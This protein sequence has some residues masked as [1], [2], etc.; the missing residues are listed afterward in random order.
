[1]QAQVDDYD[2]EAL[3]ELLKRFDVRDPE[4][5]GALSAPYPFNLMFETSIGPTGVH[6]GFLRPE[7]AQG[8][9]V[10]FA[11]LLEFNGGR[12][13]FAGAT[14]G[15]AFRNE[16]SPRAGLLRVRE[17]TLAEI[18]HFID[19]AE[20]VHI[21]FSRV[22]NVVLTLFPRDNQVT[23][24]TMV[25]MTVGD[26]V[27]QRVIGGEN[28]GYFMARTALF[29][30]DMGARKEGLRF[31]QHLANEM[32]HYASDCWD[33]EL[34]TSYGWIECV[35]HANRS[36]Y[37]LSVHSAASNTNMHYFKPFAEPVV[38]DVLC[39]KANKGAVGQAFKADAKQLLPFI[40]SLRGD[41]CVPLQ[42]AL[43]D[44]GVCT[45]KLHD[46]SFDLTANMVEFSVVTEKVAGESI[47]PAVIEPSYGIGRIIYSILEQ[48]Y[49]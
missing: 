2:V 45:V 22:A 31:R 16:I 30:W 14:I 48:S 1:M 46:K 39:A 21:K 43:K 23:T 34:L 10:N 27:R 8:I 11:R 36:C 41:V 18:E 32:A 6:R 33:A 13:P 25:R 19:P 47:T 17:F 20:D 42:Q 26:A 12:I 4:D 38:R 49:W 35:G 37:D 44:K 7:L 24:G 5:G 29:L 28:L 40:E 15:P 3:G 9:F